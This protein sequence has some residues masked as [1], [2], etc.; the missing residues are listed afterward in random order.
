MATPTVRIRP[1]TSV[2]VEPAADL[3]R[4][5]DFG[6]RLDFFRWAIERPWMDVLVAVNGDRILGTGTDRTTAGPA[7]SA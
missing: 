5:G 4:R 1:M 2:D 3:L 6:D 7:G